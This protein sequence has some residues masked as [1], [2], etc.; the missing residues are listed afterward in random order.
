[1]PPIKNRPVNQLYAVLSD[2]SVRKV[3]MTQ[4][5]APAI[6]SIFIE[7]GNFLLTPDT[8]EIE[9]DG[10][11]STGE[12]EILYINFTLPAYLIDAIA[13]PI[14]ITVLDLG[15]EKEPIKYIVWAEDAAGKHP[16]YYFQTFDSRK[17]LHNKHILVY[18]SQTYSSFQ[19][20]AFIVEETVSAFHRNGKFYFKSYANANKVFGLSD[21]Y[22]AATDDEIDR[23]SKN[24]KVKMD[25]LWFQGNTNSAIRKQITLLQK[26]KILDRA[27][28]KKVKDEAAA[29]N[30][31]IEVKSGKIHFPND[32]KVCKDILCFLNEHFYFGAITG[33]KLRA[34]SH[35]RIP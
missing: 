7:Q 9:F 18:E 34:S 1:M 31:Q 10:N 15:K 22:H 33:D 13:Q 35:R 16:V 2:E 8:T 5:I 21:F 4:D 25:S 3:S 32:T 11:Y 26:N 28:P 19:K 12:D 6:R 17:L 20:Q 30:L 23:L 27:D 14:S 24:S 29:F